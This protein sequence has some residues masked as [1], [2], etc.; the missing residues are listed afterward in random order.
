M[1]GP[2]PVLNEAQAAIAPEGSAAR[3]MMNLIGKS[4]GTD[5]RDGTPG[6]ST[7]YA[8]GRFNPAERGGREADLTQ[9]SI[10]EVREFQRGMLNNQQGNQL[11]SS[12]V[13]RYQVMG[14]TLDGL[15]RQGVVRPDEKFDAATQ[16]R[17][18]LHLMNRRGLSR[19]QQG[20]M[21]AAELQNQLAGEWA[22]IPRADTG[23]GNYAGQRAH[24][25]GS[26]VMAALQGQN[27]APRAGT[28]RQAPVP[29]MA[30]AAPAA[31]AAPPVVSAPQD[32]NP[33]VSGA[34]ALRDT[35]AA[36]A[37]AP[38]LAAGQGGAAAPYLA[39]PPGASPQDSTP[40]T[41]VGAEPPPGTPLP[42]RA[43][44]GLPTTPIPAEE[45]ERQQAQQEARTRVD[46]A[47][48]TTVEIP[49]VRIELANAAGETVHTQHLPSTTVTAPR[50]WGSGR[51]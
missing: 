3:A 48:S 27:P 15:I 36:T 13:G 18:A 9:M 51:S 49:P 50:A 22:S 42:E 26:E 45:R 30:S 14:Y 40:P 1:G 16:D 25:S 37:P 2:G 24:V 8:H 47:S 44:G 19:H 43:Q 7:T 28:T 21:S 31:A 5:R 41:I 10:A 32:T 38:A 35:Q 6:Y 17:I 23:Q 29:S 39:P 46:V 11:R 34:E 12:A 33:V 4:E 20:R